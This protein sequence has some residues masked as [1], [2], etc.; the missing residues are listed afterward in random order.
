MI[1]SHKSVLLQEAVDALRVK[2]GAVYIDA[3]L[4]G[5]GHTEHILK[6]GGI[7]LGIDQDP[8][9]I[10]FVSQR[11]QDFQNLTIARGNF[12]DMTEIARE[13]G[14]EKVSGILF[15]LGLSSNQL[16]HSGRGFSF[17]KDEELDMRMDP[18]N[19][20]TAYEI[21]NKWTGD[22]LHA[23]FTKYGEEHHAKK[24]VDEI[25]RVRRESPIVKS[26]ELSELI[27]KTVGGRGEIHPATRIFQALRIAVNDELAR[28]KKALA[29][30]F[31]LLSVNGRIAVI[32]FHSLEDRI[33]KNEFREL[34]IKRGAHIITAKPIVPTD[35][36]IQINKRARSAKLR[37][38]EK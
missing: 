23:L 2:P 4:G 6:K 9:S 32:T 29:D 34:S 19:Q 17:R 3:T 16:E 12:S 11:L 33:V 1:Y 26:S 27:I 24:I 15:D 25:V 14:L 21:I 36:E 28:I 31:E 13:N 20:L 22:E 7:V 35:E 8:D 38:L 30:G 10:A 37:V 5:G 18:R